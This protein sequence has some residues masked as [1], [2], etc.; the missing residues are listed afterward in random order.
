MLHSTCNIH[1]QGAPRIEVRSDI[2][3]LY[4]VVQ[5]QSVGLSVG[6]SVRIRQFLRNRLMDF[7]QILGDDSMSEYAWVFFRIFDIVIFDL[8]RSIFR[9]K[10]VILRT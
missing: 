6:L 3:H 1:I 10:I 7:A 2:T 5:H 4:A 9:S 8:F